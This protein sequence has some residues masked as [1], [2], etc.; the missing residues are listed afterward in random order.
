[1]VARYGEFVRYRPRFS[2]ATAL[3]WLAPGILLLLGVLIVVVTLRGRRKP[4]SAEAELT[5]EEQ[6]RLRDLIAKAEK[7]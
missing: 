7:P 6:R 5:E 1:M 3:L 4:G 2:G